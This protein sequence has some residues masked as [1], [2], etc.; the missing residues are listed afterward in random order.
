M[1]ETEVRTELRNWI[2]MRAKMPPA[3]ELH[4]STPILDQGIL[5]SLDVAELILYIESL[6]GEEVDIAA[7]EPK[8]LKNVDTLYI[9]FFGDGPQAVS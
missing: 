7:I 5:S 1:T 9:A 2:R 4:D 8:V 3:K 6:K